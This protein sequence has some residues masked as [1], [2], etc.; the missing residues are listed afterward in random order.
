M[1]QKSDWD[2]VNRELLARERLALG[3]PPSDEELLAFAQGRLSPEERARVQELLVCYPDLA[4][5]VVQPFPEPQAAENELSQEELAHDWAAIAARLTAPDRRQAAAPL[6]WR[7]RQAPGV[8]ALLGWRLAT[9]AAAVLAVAF[10]GLLYQSQVQVQRQAE[11]L[12]KPRINPDVRLLLPDGRRGG[13]EPQPPIQLPVSGDNLLLR[14]ALI[15]A[16]SFPDYRMDVVDLAGSAPRLIWSQ[17]GLR[18]RVDDTLDVWVPRS[19]LPALDYRLEVYGLGAGPPRRLA[20]YTI[21]LA[22]G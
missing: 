13:G 18:R 2:A 1:I 14:A 12:R 16:P 7:P 22:R 20:S 10:A 5:A 3:P 8:H 15:N 4:R 11:E 17:A 9:G 6:R 19:F 21:H